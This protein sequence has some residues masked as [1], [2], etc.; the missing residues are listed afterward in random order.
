MN[1]LYKIEMCRVSCSY[2]TF[3]VEAD[4]EDEAEEKA[5]AMAGDSLYIEGSADYELEDLREIAND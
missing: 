1:K 2:A 5:Y 4:S 3:H